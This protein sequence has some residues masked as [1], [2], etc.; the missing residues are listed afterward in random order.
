MVDFSGFDFAADIECVSD[1][2]IACKCVCAQ[3]EQQEYY[4]RYA[5]TNR[6]RPPE[7]SPI[8]TWTPAFSS[9]RMILAV[10]PATQSTFRQ[11]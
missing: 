6:D 1:C 11:I 7:L 5:R 3:N 2:V 9:L 10:V 8:A 4:E